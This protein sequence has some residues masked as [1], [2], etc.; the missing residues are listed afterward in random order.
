MLRRCEF[1]L[2]TGLITFYSSSIPDITGSLTV[3]G[4]NTFTVIGP[5]KLEGSLE[6]SGT[7]AAARLFLVSPI[8]FPVA[9]SPNSSKNSKW[10]CACPVSHSA[11]DLKTEATSLYPSTSAF[12]AK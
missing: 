6:S 9:G 4:S 10:P 3:S 2:R 11:V 12:C 1:S 8:G 5:T 7:L